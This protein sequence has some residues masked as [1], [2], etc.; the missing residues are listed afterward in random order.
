MLDGERSSGAAHAGHDFVGDQENAVVAA[1]FRDAR[2]VAFRRRGSTESRAGDWLKD[3]SGGVLLLA[4][5]QES[6]QI[7]G[8]REFALR[9]S[10]FEWAAIAIARSDVSPFGEERLVGGAARHV[11]A[12]GHRAES[13]AM[14]ALAAREDAVA[15]LLAAFEVK[16]ARKFYDRFGGFGAAGSKI[17]AAAVAKIRWRHGEQPRGK[18]FRRSVVK[19]RSMRE[20]NLRRLLGHG[21]ADFGDTV[22]D[23]DDRGLAGSVEKPAAIVS[24]N[25]ATFPARGN[26]KVLVEM[27]GEKSAARGHEMSGKEL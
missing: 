2:G 23:V 6:L 11:S 4:L 27:A 5:G 13:A 20:S 17:D 25:P 1:N 19:L 18:F 14:I 15:I 3:K 24:D 16:L 21:A 12:D 8:A 9:K 22:T 10:F 7:V 26:R